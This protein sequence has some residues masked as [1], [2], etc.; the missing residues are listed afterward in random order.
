MLF[1]SVFVA[2]SLTIPSC[3]HKPKTVVVHDFCLITKPICAKKTDD[4][5]TREQVAEYNNIGIAM[6]GWTKETAEKAC[7]QDERV[8]AQ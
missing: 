5:F 2:V 4:A 8:I 1:V 3:V 6:C 7:R